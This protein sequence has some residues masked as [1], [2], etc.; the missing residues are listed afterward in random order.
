MSR[1]GLIMS[2]RRRTER[3]IYYAQNYRGK[4]N[5][6]KEKNYLQKTL[7]CNGRRGL[8]SIVRLGQWLKQI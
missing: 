3:T 7:T 8:K 2:V 1:L 6:M 5:F 4:E